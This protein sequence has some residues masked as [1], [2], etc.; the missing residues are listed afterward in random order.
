MLY[1]RAYGKEGQ[2]YVQAAYSAKDFVLPN[3]EETAGRT[4]M[5]E[6]LLFVIRNS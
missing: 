4:T 2:R 1:Y 5:N 6:N 3:S